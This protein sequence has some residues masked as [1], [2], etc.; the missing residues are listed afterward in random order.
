MRDRDKL[1]NTFTSLPIKCIIFTHSLKRANKMI[2]KQLT[3]QPELAKA[4]QTHA[5]LY[6]DGNFNMAV[7]SLCRGGLGL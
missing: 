2:R 3:I 1:K 7:R 4:I 5:D 6:F